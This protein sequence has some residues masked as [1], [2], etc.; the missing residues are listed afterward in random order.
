MLGLFSRPPRTAAASPRVSV[1][2][3]SYRHAAFVQDCVRSVLEQDFQDFEIVVTDDGSGDATPERIA[4]LAEPRVRLNVFPENRGACVALNDAI[5]RSR[6]RYVAVLNSDDRFLPGKLRRQVD[7]LDSR[8]ELGAVF[9]L[10]SF[11]D[12]RGQPFDDPAHKDVVAFDAA[13]LTR[14]E[15]L[16]R[17]FDHGNSLCHPTAMIRREVFDRVGLYDPRLAQV[18]DL[19]QWIRVCT[20]FEIEVM[21]EPLTSFRILDGQRNASAARPEVVVRDAWERACV[22]R[23]YLRLPEPELLAV[24]PEFAGQPGSAAERLALYALRRPEPFFRRFALDA[25]FDALPD[26]RAAAHATGADPGAWRRFIDATGRCD[27]HRLYS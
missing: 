10:A 22:L 1:V 13:R 21:P 3:P 24:F 6:G 2:I 7:L 8:P 17:F 25:W 12:E 14:H 9:G 5:L 15:W 26:G 23:H 4:E 20:A 19:D 11:V 27:L 18:P 16:R